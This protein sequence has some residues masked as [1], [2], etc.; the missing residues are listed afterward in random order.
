MPLVDFNQL[1][2]SARTRAKAILD[3]GLTISKEDGVPAKVEPI[4]AQ[5]IVQAIVE[6]AAKEN[7]DLIVIGTRGMTGFKKLLVGSVSSGV[8]TNA[9]CSVLVVR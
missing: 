6:L 1:E 4:E 5:S 8:V 2:E 7:F 3:R 9:N